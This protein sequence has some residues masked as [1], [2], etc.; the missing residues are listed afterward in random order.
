MGD[1]LRTQFLAKSPAAGSQLVR[2]HRPAS[3]F[4]RAL[5]GA[6]SF[7]PRAS[8]GLLPALATPDSSPNNPWS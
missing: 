5:Q 3:G 2:E 4:S 8:R 7:P 6:P 1:T